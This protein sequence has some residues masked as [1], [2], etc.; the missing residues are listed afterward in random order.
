M[1]LRHALA[2]GALALL[3]ALPA[4]AAQTYRLPGD[5][6]YIW[7]PAGEV[8]IEA[9]TGTAVEVVVTLQGS[10]ARELTINDQALNG[11]PT[12]RVLYPGHTII[13]PPMGRWSN[14]NTNVHGDGTWGDHSGWSGHRLTVKGS[15]SGTEGWADLV[16]RVPKGRKVSVFSIAGSGEVRGVDGN[17]SFDGGSGGAQVEDCRGKHTLDLGSGGVEVNGFKG[18]LNV[19][20]GSGSVKVNDVEGPSVRLDTGSGG[21]TGDDIVADEL[22]V[23][24]GSGS[25]ELS[26]VDARRGQVDPGSGG[27]E[28]GLLTSTPDLDIDT[29]S[30]SVR[31]TL[32]S[33]LSARLHIETGSG[34]I[35]SELPLTIDEKDT[36]ILRG[37]AGSGAGR[38][39][40]DTGSGGVSLLASNV[41][42]P[43]KGKTTKGRRCGRGRSRAGPRAAATRQRLEA[44][45]HRIP[46]NQDHPPEQIETS[47][48]ARP[49]PSVREAREVRRDTRG[50]P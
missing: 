24:T 35:R 9:T 4:T 1:T 50:K 22:L 15:G 44:L 36:G 27:V 11:R 33:N 17:V 38:L 29:G 37:T 3:P 48:R 6:V 28:M 32:P 34:G 19:D 2:L 31:V 45:P 23:D 30:G 42:A 16:V 7:N 46:Q 40:V 47:S 49:G 13:Y 10:D 14:S 41:S 5:D 8:R 39:H 43:S 20:T 18:D 12:L 26:R 21:V 25:V